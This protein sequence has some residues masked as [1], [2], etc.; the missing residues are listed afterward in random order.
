MLYKYN[1]FFFNDKANIRSL[2]KGKFSLKEYTMQ[3]QYQFNNF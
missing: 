1:K 3:N 2:L